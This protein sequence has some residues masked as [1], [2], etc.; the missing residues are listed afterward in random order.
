MKSFRLILG[1]GLLAAGFSACGKAPPQP[2]QVYESRG[3]VRQLPATNAP[4]PEVYIQHEAID[5]FVDHD[6]NVVGMESMAMPFPVAKIDDLEG[7]A[8]G[9]KIAF[10]FEVRWEGGHPL[11]LTE[12]QAL[13]SDTRLGFEATPSE[14]EVNTAEPTG[15]ASTTT[16]EP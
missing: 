5:E 3:I 11:R 12:L 1:I 10:S 15:E 6:G 9:D 2:A 8:V 13:P 14:P 4:K 16:P 7:L